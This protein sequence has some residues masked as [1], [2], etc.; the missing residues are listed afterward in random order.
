MRFS[1]FTCLAILFA[2]F[3]AVPCALGQDKRAIERCQAELADASNKR[4]KANIAMQKAY[5][6]AEDALNALKGSGAR[7][8]ISDLSRVLKETL[9]DSR[10]TLATTKR[11]RSRM[12]ALDSF[13]KGLPKAMERMENAS[14]KL[15]P[16]T[17]TKLINTLWRE[18]AKKNDLPSDDDLATSVFERITTE[19]PFHQLWNEELSQTLPVSQDWAQCSE[20]VKDLEQ[21]LIV[22]KDPKMAYAINAPDGMARIPGG[23]V[24]VEGLYGY[25]LKRRTVKVRTFY[26]DRFEV[27]H[28]DY[29]TNFY[30]KLTDTK[31]SQS[32]LPKD[33]NQNA[34]WSQNPET[35]SYE[36]SK[37][38][39]DLPVTGIDLFSAAAYA[40]AVGKRLPTES[41]WLLGASGSERGQA[42]FPMGDK[43]DI[44]HINHKGS[45]ND[46]P[47]PVNSLPE[48]RSRFGLH[49]VAGNAMEWTWTV[50]EKSTDIKGEKPP[51]DKPVVVRGGSYDSP[52]R[53]CSS[54]ARWAALPKGT[55]DPTLGFRCAQDAK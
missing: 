41:E 9:S 53:S 52:L 19:I 3:I 12:R 16:E 36:P 4:D 8:A 33:L 46:G 39:R 48:G 25:T 22:L 26:I 37:E 42:R 43:A 49:H 54:K 28:G 18:A 21:K 40:K 17:I 6:S 45:G 7:P 29:W 5:R 34:T 11:A 47:L 50:V 30:S 38:Q 10:A 44:Q 23:S 35:G 2:G 51:A 24:V 32:H 15:I 20:T 31:E 13:Q 14:L 55:A 1:R 27:S